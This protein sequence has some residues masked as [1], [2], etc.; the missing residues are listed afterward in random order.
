MSPL[1]VREASEGDVLTSGTVLLAPG[2]RHLT[3]RKQADGTVTAHLDSKPFELLHR[4]SVDVLFQS[5]SKVYG[6]RVLAVVMTG[7]G[8]DGTQGAAWIKSQGGIVYTESAESCI[9]YGMPGSVVEAGLSDRQFPLEQ[10]ATAIQET[11]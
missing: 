6:D 10:L 8:N 5:A 4:P 9:V 3:M 2:G 7:M 1:S 11:V